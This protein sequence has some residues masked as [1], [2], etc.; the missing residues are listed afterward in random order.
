MNKARRKKIADLRTALESLK[1]NLDLIRDEEQ[2]AFDA[3]PE[4]IQGSEKGTDMEEG[5]EAL[6]DSFD[7]LESVIDR[8]ESFQ[9]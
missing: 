9:V 5:L 8:L 4:S 7:E 2:E 3:M 6:N 1:E